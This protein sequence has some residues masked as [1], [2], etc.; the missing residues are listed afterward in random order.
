MA[1]RVRGGL[2][3]PRANA[4]WPLASLE[5]TAER[6]RIGSPFGRL[7]IERADIEAIHAH[8]GII[9][10]GV[11]IVLKQ[12]HARFGDPIFWY[13][14]TERLLDDLAELGWPVQR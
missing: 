8:R 5:C 10:R 12:R 2:R 7:L 3:I 9:S 11:Q 6:L 13:G 1:L 4:S 14:K